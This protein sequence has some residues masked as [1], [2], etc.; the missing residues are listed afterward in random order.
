MSA[1]VEICSKCGKARTRTKNG[2]GN[3][4]IP[5]ERERKRIYAAK[6]MVAKR[7]AKAAAAP[8]LPEPE[9]V[10][11]DAAAARESAVILAQHQTNLKA[12]A[13]EL[14]EV[15]RLRERSAAITS[16]CT[17]QAELLDR[18]AEDGASDEELGVAS[19]RQAG[20]G[21]RREHATKHQHAAELSLQ[22]RL[23]ADI[24]AQAR[25]EWAWTG[26]VLERETERFS[27]LIVENQRV[28]LLETCRQL[29]QVSI[30]Y[31]G[32]L[33]S[34]GERALESWAW[35]RPLDE[36]ASQ[37]TAYSAQVVP[38]PIFKPPPRE[39]IVGFLLE[40]VQKTIKRWELLLA[41]VEGCAGFALP[42]YEE[43]VPEPE[44]P[45][46]YPDTTQ[47]VHAF[48][49][50]ADLDKPDYEVPVFTPRTP[51]QPGAAA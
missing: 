44:V 14:A 1:A 35:S 49:T 38:D 28:G 20:L 17:S 2:K 13:A 23:S 12:L 50:P 32:K 19:N 33:D 16:E 8:D 46:V 31:Q 47:N 9:V 18:L 45:P 15:V 40:A 4:C 27:L 43:P 22:R 5:C 48:W 21:V 7:A 37:K 36:P 26:F 42:S 10:A 11:V 51:G 29:A 41:A 30:S 6:R 25:L 39:E 24:K 3:E 34:L